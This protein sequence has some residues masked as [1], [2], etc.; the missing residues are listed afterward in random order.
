VNS[1]R[2]APVIADV[3][4]A[5][6]VSVPTVSRVLTGS[7]P[8]SDEKRERVLRAIEMLGYRPN[9][10]ARALVRGSQPLV[11][12]FAGNTTRYG[13]ART[14]QGIEEAARAA[15][16]IVVITV[17]ESEDEAEVRAAVDLVLGQTI[18]GAI[19][20]DYD[21]QGATTLQAIG[22][23]VPTVVATPSA[24]YSTFP[25]ITMDDE[26]AGREAT[27]YLLGLGHR[28]VHHIA[29][30]HS[31]G[32]GGRAVGWRTALE[33]AGAEVPDIIGADW[34]PMSGYRA[35]QQLAAIGDATAVLCGNDELAMGVARAL[36]EAGLRI[37]QDVSIIGFDDQ[38]LAELWQPALTTVRQDFVELGRQAYALLDGV[39]AR[40]TSR[41]I[42]RA[43]PELIVRESTAAPAPERL[44]AARS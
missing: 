28:T 27:E 29:I 33:A 41:R 42:E 13:Y 5:A 6:G 4:R 39:I 40:T 21:P 44:A 22:D 34:E 23:S 17:I 3:A 37:P 19:V 11:A 9:A 20:L 15:G 12:V 8:V 36:A 26:T 38:P 30:P 1:P 10:A 18:S 43:K 2:R 16:R 31:G 14:I 7:T 32:P 24:G 25:S 35:G